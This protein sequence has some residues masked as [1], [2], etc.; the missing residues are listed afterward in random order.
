V[1]GYVV[2]GVSAAP[3]VQFRVFQPWLHDLLVVLSE[4]GLPP[5]AG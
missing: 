4:S 1:A 3:W 2:G 5:A